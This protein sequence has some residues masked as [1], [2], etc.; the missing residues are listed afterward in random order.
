MRIQETPLPSDIGIQEEFYPD[1]AR[2][3]SLRCNFLWTLAGNVVYAACQWGMLVVLAKLGSPEMVGQF[4]LGLAITAPIFMFSNLQ[5]RAVQATDARREYLFGHYLA[6]R[7]LTVILAFLVIGGITGLSSYSWGTKL[8]ILAVGLA[9]A[10]EAVSDVFYGLFQ[11]HERLDRIAT[12]MMI[13]GPLSLAALGSVFYLTGSMFWGALGLVAAWAVVLL[14]YDMYRGA[15]ILAV[16]AS[17][18]GRNTSPLVRRRLVLQLPWEPATLSRLAWLALPLGFVMMVISLKTN[19]PRY[20]IEHYLGERQLGIFA[21]MAYFMMAG[22]QVVGALGQSA[23]PRLA[24]YYAAGRK[25]AMFTLLVKLM[26]LG[27]LLGVAGVLVALMAG[28]E[29]L[30]LVYRAEYAEKAGVLAW[31][32]AAAGIYYI[33]VFLGF[34][35]TA[36]RYFRIQAPLNAVTLLLITGVSALLIPRYG[37][38]GAAWVACVVYTVEIPLKAWIMAH[39]FKHFPVN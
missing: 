36:A 2:G 13:K 35:M 31:L 24:K 32:M 29:I 33:G 5:L 20:F 4:A 21:A 27:G 1:S 18:S 38:V 17:N 30:T 23:T 10:F 7:L 26:L 16:A 9:K 39:A 14:A 34:G 19:I 25:G 37:L 8:V 22:K 11:Q 3:L 6:L 12:S 28:K 15:Q